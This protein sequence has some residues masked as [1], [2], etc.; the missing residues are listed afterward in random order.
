V[1]GKIII[2][3]E[4]LCRLIGL[5]TNKP[6]EQVTLKY[7]AKKDGGCLAKIQSG[8]IYEVSHIKINDKDFAIDFSDEANL[9]NNLYSIS[10]NKVLLNT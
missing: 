5:I 7:K 8:L 4:H 1:N 10:I 9:L 2:T 3:G 6:A